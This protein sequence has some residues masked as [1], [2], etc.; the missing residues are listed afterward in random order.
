LK[1]LLKKHKKHR[2]TSLELLLEKVENQKNLRR[3][4]V[5]FQRFQELA[6]TVED[7]A[8]NLF[9]EKLS[10]FNKHNTAYR[11]LSDYHFFRLFPDFEHCYQLL[12]HF[13][14]NKKFEQANRLSSV[15][16]KR[17]GDDERLILADIKGKAQSGLIKEAYDNLLEA[18]NKGFTVSD[19]YYK[20]FLRAAVKG[21]PE[22]FDFFF[23]IDPLPN[24]TESEKEIL[25]EFSAVKAILSGDSSLALKECKETGLGWPKLADKLIR[26]AKR[27][28]TKEFDTSLTKFFEDAELEEHPLS[29]QQKKLLLS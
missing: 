8:A 3:A 25:K 24:Q 23:V 16:R 22:V 12:I 27:V 26:L 5:I 2:L 6:I 19:S 18:R 20:T 7:R 11:Y 17:F 9:I 4:V 13:Y 1:D 29:D 28:Q 14:V 21:K 15:L 10:R